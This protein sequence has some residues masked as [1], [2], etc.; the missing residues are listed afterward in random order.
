MDFQ[1]CIFLTHS[2]LKN[3]IVQS[4][5]TGS[6][7]GGV[8]GGVG[9]LIIITITITIIIIGAVIKH[10]RKDRRKHKVTLNTEGWS[11]VQR[12]C[13]FNR[14]YIDSRGGKKRCVGVDVC[15]V[16]T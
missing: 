16:T 2:L 10:H 9:G 11:L 15:T 5:L 1:L 8:I 3:Y 12:T 14:S 13:V 6:I 7:I 4:F